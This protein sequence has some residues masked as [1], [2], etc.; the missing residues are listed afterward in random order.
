[1]LWIGLAFLVG[2]VF[3]QRFEL[4][5]FGATFAMMW[6]SAHASRSSAICIA[7]RE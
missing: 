7:W 6:S 5:R 2:A 4:W 1:M 3:G